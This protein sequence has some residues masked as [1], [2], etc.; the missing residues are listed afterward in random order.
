VRAAQADVVDGDQPVA[1]P[2]DVAGVQAHVGGRRAAEA[3]PPRPAGRAEPVGQDRELVGGL[4]REEVELGLAVGGERSVAVQVVGREVQQG[5]G[6][7]REGD[8]VLELER[9]GLGD[10]HRVGRHVQA[11]QRG[12]DVAGDGRGDARLA[13]D[14]PEQLD[15][16]RLAVRA[17]HGDER[18]GQQ[19]PGQLELAHDLDPALASG[20]DHRGLLRDARRLDHG[21]DAVEQVDPV[22]LQVHPV[23][24]LGARRRAAVHPDRR[25]PL[26][27]ERAQGGDAAAREADD[28]DR[29]RRERRPRHVIDCWYSVKAIALQIAATIQKRRMIFVSDQPSSSKW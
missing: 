11:G 4:P 2:G 23:E 24:A 27:A 15:R 7:G 20:R 21:R 5:A 10:D 26:A 1:L 9:G 16:R 8:R 17:G 13:M 14:V 22:G 28:E 18:V 6:L 12:A 19:A 3:Q 29:A 25:D